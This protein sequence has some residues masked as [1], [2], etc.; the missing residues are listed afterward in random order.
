MPR[1]RILG[2]LDDRSRE[3][4]HRYI[5]ESPARQ[6]GWVAPEAPEVYQVT[7][8]YLDAF[9]ELAANFGLTVNP[10]EGIPAPS[11]PPVPGS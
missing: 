10:E 9:F 4:F 11:A 7:S 3:R 1:L 8:D 2:G 6:E 5:T